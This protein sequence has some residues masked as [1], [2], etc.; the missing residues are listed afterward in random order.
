LQVARA[1][2]QPSSIAEALCELGSVRLDQGDLERAGPLIAEGVALARAVGDKRVEAQ[3]LEIA[4]LWATQ[5]GDLVDAGVHFEGCLGLGRAIG[6]SGFQVNA[7]LYLGMLAL[8][9]GD[10]AGAVESAKESL[11]LI[12]RTLP[13]VNRERVAN[14]I[15]VLASAA[16]AMGQSTRAAQLFGAHAAL[17]EDLGLPSDAGLP[18]A[19]LQRRLQDA[20]RAAEAAVRGALG[21]TAF[22]VA[23]E[24]GKGLTLEE[25]FAFA[26]TVSGSATE[27]GA[28]GAG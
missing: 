5:Q 18:E 19:H 11:A 24:K 12:Q 15:R 8:A 21:E 26:D 25:V 1:V 17:E 20:A 22:A 3:A 7:L 27:S 14:N 23:W 13:D 28:S 10:V 2:G 4:G 6:N 16:V 9:R